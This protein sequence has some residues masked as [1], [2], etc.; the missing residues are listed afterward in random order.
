MYHRLV[1]IKKQIRKFIANFSVAEE[2]GKEYIFDGDVIRE[3][4]D[5]STYDENGDIIPLED[6]EYTIQG[7][8]VVIVDGK[9]SELPEK[10][11]KVELNNTDES[12]PVDSEALTHEPDGR[13][14]KQVDSA[15]DAEG[16]E[17]RIAE[18]EAENNALKSELE[19]LKKELS[20]IKQTPMA[21]PVPQRTNL[22]SQ[23]EDTEVSEAVKGTKFE[24]ACKIFGSK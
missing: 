1:E 19:A 4:L 8:K 6:G 13:D 14:N 24:K 23:K 10:E 9:V 7:V 2:D 21:K 20:E 5:I 22:A 12:T 17:V 3:G 18:L 15:N 11:S 16:N